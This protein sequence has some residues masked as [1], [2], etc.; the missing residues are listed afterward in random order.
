MLVRIKKWLPFGEKRDD[1]AGSGGGGRSS[2]AAPQQA[3]TQVKSPAWQ[4][5]AEM[6][7]VIGGIL[8]ARLHQKRY[9]PDQASELSKGLCTEIKEKV[10]EQWW[11][12]HQFVVH[13]KLGEAQGACAD[14]VA[15]CG[16]GVQVSFQSILQCQHPS[17]PAHSASIL[18]L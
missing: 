6:R 8:E 7:E 4:V 17:S 18:P 13:V 16:Y 5:R 1:G 11:P 14:S 9:D 12:G 10:K 3:Q 2:A 15:V